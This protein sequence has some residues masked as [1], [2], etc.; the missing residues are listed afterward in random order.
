MNQ[1]LRPTQSL[2]V[3]YTELPKNLYSRKGVSLSE[4]ATTSEEYTTHYV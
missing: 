4:R 2:K 3:S 1:T